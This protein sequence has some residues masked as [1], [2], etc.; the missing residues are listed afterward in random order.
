V[1][2]QRWPPA[3]PAVGRGQRPQLVALGGVDGVAVDQRADVRS[4]SNPIGNWTDQRCWPLASKASTAALRGGSSGSSQPRPGWGRMRP[5]ESEP[6]AA[7]VLAACLS[8]PAWSAWSQA[9]SPATPSRA[10]AARRLRKIR[11][12]SPVCAPGRPHQYDGALGQGFPMA[13]SSR[14]QRRSW[15]RPATL[16]SALD[17]VVQVGSRSRSQALLLR[18][19]RPAPHRPWCW[20]Q[21]FWAAAW[22]SSLEVRAC[23][24]TVRRGHLGWP[25]ARPWI[26]PGR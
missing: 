23:M 21:N 14:Q 16:T 2:A 6:A 17:P 24:A 4:I 3:L 19:A 22:W 12:M 18:S 15:P 25:F 13:T 26:A 11:P 5:G 10:S 8:V 1:A 20:T 9:A 7:S